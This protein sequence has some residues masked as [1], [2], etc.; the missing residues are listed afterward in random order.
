MI[1]LLNEEVKILRY[2]N[3]HPNRTFTEIYK[4]FPEFSSC[5]YSLERDGL[6]KCKDPNECLMGNTY[7]NLNNPTVI[8]IAR[9]GIKYLESHRLFTMPY[10][11]SNL[12]IPIIVGVASAVIAAIILAA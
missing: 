1:E 12:I 10:I 3:R 11:V 4:R 9:A 5:W 2:I 6:I 7:D 8:N